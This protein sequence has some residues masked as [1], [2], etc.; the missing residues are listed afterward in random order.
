MKH[1][2][3]TFCLLTCSALSATATEPIVVES[4]VLQLIDH[5]DLAAGESGLLVELNASEG[6][7]FAKGD[8]IARIDDTD[9]R[10]AEQAA[11]AELA[12]AKAKAEND[13]A[14]RTAAAAQRVAEA[15]LA[16]SEES[17]AKFAKSVSQSQMDIERLNVDKLKLEVE[18][19]KHELHLARLSQTVAQRKLEAARLEIERRR[20]LAPIAGVAVDI[21]ASVGE[22][23]EPGQKLVRVVSTH[24]LKAEGFVAADQAAQ[25]LDGWQ[26]E[27]ELADGSRVTGGVVFVSPE[28]DPINKQ[29]RLWAE[30]ENSEGRLRPGQTVSMQLQPPVDR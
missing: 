28:I 30:V 9:A 7:T 11:E 4:A 21:E 16:R 2:L 3:L 15:E 23:V 5:A 19:G 24:R 8:V 13:V 14:I 18:A 20:V 6:K 12:L 10:I 1:Y 29:V 17:I 22:W 26:A 25:G 27:I